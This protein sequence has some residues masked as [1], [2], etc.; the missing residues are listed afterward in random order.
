M[1]FINHDV[2]NNKE[3]KTYVHP[4]QMNSIR[5]KDRNVGIVW[6]MKPVSSTELEGQN[7]HQNEGIG[8]AFSHIRASLKRLQGSNSKC[9]GST[10]YVYE[11]SNDKKRQLQF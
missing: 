9:S 3:N 5:T 8:Q 2:L 1:D 11:S 6:R 4:F 10:K 7:G